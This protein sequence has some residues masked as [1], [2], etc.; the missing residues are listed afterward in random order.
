MRI[1]FRNPGSVQWTFLGVVLLTREDL[2]YPGLSSVIS[3][4]HVL[5]YSEHETVP[6]YLVLPTQLPHFL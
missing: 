3:D 5:T 6:H 2:T 4:D 1:N